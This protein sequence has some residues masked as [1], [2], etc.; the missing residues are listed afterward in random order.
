MKIG[1]PKLS[2][3]TGQRSGLL[4]TPTNVAPSVILEGEDYGLK[5][6]INAEPSHGRSCAKLNGRADRVSDL[7]VPSDRH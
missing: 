2:E 7:V 1:Q 3:R 5:A 4:V 6:S